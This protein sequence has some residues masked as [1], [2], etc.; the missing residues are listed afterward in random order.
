M[1]VK[2]EKREAGTGGLPLSVGQHLRVASD[3]C[4]AGPLR[5]H[6]ACVHPPPRI[7]PSSSKP[8]P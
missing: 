6:A 1:Y 4:A 8:T 3:L 2:R 5:R 7:R